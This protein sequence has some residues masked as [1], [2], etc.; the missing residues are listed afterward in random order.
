M[1][2]ENKKKKKTKEKT[3][4]KQIKIHSLARIGK[5]ITS[6]MILSK[7]SLFLFFCF[8]LI[9]SSFKFHECC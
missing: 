5:E 8:F 1:K 7:I 3:K 4:E 6:Q 2:I 9:E